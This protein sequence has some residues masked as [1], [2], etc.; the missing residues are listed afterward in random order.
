MSS[1]GFE[2]STT[3][4]TRNTS[5]RSPTRCIRNTRPLPTPAFCL[6]IGDPCL[7]TQYVFDAKCRSRIA[8]SGPR[9]ASKRSIMR[10]AVCPKGKSFPHLLLDRH[11]PAHQRHGTQEHYRYHSRDPRRRLFVRRRP[12]VHEWK[13]WGQ[14][15]AAAQ[16]FDSH[17][18]THSTHSGVRVDHPEFVCDRILRYARACWTADCGF[19]TFAGP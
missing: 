11:G 14:S 7:V 19:G 15:I 10:C 5:S 16:D 9:C 13:V 12:S 4:R 2:T 3:K 18:I 17:V 8:A 6:Q 1:S